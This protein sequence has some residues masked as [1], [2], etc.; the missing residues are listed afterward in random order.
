[1]DAYTL[2]QQAPKIQTEFDHKNKGYNFLTKIVLLVDFKEHKTTITKEVYY[3][4][5]K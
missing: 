4:A 1:M 3:E 5:S 2:L